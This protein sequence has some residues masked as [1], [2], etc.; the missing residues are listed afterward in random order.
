M[1]TFNA[2]SDHLSLISSPGPD[3][4]ITDEPV[5]CYWRNALIIVERGFKTDLASIPAG[6]RWLI[7]NDN[8]KVR[9]AAIVHDYLCVT[10]G[11]IVGANLSSVESAELF[12][13]ALRH[14]KL[15]RVTAWLMYWAVRL[16]G[17]QW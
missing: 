10:R 6:F 4:W 5:V 2:E 8:P 1:I 17:P 13:D 15:N 7:S 9:R 16:G 14:D 11:R 3:S 12:Y